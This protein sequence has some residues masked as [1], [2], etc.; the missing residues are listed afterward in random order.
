MQL[1]Y[2]VVKNALRVLLAHTRAKKN[3]HENFDS[4]HLS[5]FL[6]FIHSFFPYCKTTILGDHLVI[7]CD[8]SCPPHVRD[9]DEVINVG[10]QELQQLVGEDGV[11]IGKAK[12]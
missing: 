1:G 12:E 6:S 5:F 2:S 3:K 7:G 11:E 10:V 9:A 4:V 8:N